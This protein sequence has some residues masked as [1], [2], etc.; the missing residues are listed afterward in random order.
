[1]SLGSVV[2]SIFRN[3]DPLTARRAGYGRDVIGLG[4]TAVTVP[5][6]LAWRAVPANPRRI[7][8]RQAV[9]GA[10][11]VDAVGSRRR[12]GPAPLDPG[13]RAG[14]HPARGPSLRG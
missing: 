11:R 8:A 6:A 10:V 7:V 14:K 1:M 12:G 3:L 9:E 13:R 4:A 5:P 2:C